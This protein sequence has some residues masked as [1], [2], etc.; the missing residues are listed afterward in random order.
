MALNTPTAMPKQ[1]SAPVY[2]Q[3]LWTGKRAFIAAFLFFNMFINYMDRINLSVAAPI[4][5]KQFKW[6]PGSHGSHFFRFHVDLH[7]LFD[8]LG[9]AD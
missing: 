8:S 4:I 3:S 7:D 2:S 1:V 5:A 9:L 6:D